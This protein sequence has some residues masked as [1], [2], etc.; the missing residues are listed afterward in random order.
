MLF[1]KT[2]QIESLPVWKQSL[3][4]SQSKYPL[5]AQTAIYFCINH[6]LPSLYFSHK[7]FLAFSNSVAFTPISTKPNVFN[8]KCGDC[9]HKITPTGS[10]WHSNIS[11]LL[12]SQPHPSLSAS[13]SDILLQRSLREKWR[14]AMCWVL[15]HTECIETLLSTLL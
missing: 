7:Y 8:R 12:S 10:E 14:E 11:F 4:Y 13:P 15:T 6:R 9:W 3:D 1:A 2:N 5:S